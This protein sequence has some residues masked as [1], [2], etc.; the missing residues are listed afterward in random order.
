LTHNRRD[1]GWV[2]ARSFQIG[3]PAFFVGGNIPE[4]RK[5]FVMSSVASNS[6]EAPS[7]CVRK[8]LS[9]IT[10]LFEIRKRFVK[11]LAAQLHDAR[12]DQTH[13]RCPSALGVA[14]FFST[15]SCSRIASSFSNGSS[16][17]LAT[18]S[19]ANLT[20]S[21]A[22]ARSRSCSGFSDLASIRM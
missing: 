7:V 20:S 12:L 11:M 4:A 6:R 3:G 14:R 13:W 21:R 9:S 2:F 5:R 1:Q 22:A 8:A 15:V 17:E 18:T 16:D 19:L 10:A